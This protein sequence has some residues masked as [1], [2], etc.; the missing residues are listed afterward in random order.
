[1]PAPSRAEPC[2]RP[3]SDP[4]LFG[5]ALGI[6]VESRIGRSGALLQACDVAQ[7]QPFLLQ[8]AVLARLHSCRFDLFP[9]ETPQV[10]EAQLFLLGAVQFFKLA[11]ATA[12]A[13][14]QIAH[15]VQ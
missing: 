11:A 3:R 6:F 8:S 12:P 9:L 5:R 15:F 1:V 13:R 14:E 4:K 10:G 7:H 2:A